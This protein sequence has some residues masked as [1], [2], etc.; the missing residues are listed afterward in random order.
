MNL[1]IFW[2]K[3]LYAVMALGKQI[4]EAYLGP[5]QTCAGKFTKILFVKSFMIDVQTIFNPPKMLQFRNIKQ[6]F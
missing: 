6:Y 5:R 1:H 2:L 3:R 4:S